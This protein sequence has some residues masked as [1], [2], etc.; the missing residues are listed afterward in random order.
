MVRKKQIEGQPENKYYDKIT[1]TFDAKG[2]RLVS[3][4]P[5]IVQIKIS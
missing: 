4:Y 1:I 3:T 5:Q 2:Q